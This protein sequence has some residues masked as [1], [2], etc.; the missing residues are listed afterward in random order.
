[1]L[2]LLVPTVALA[3]N[4]D[5]FKGDGKGNS[6]DKKTD[7]TFRLTGNEKHVKEF[8]AR[9]FTFNCN[10]RKDFK[11]NWIKFDKNFKVK[12]KNHNFSGKQSESSSGVVLKGKVSGRLDGKNDKLDEAH[13]RVQFDVKYPGTTTTAA[14]HCKSGKINWDADN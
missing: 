7:I 8:R 1:M 11:S 4:G 13:G 10:G 6:K 2:A 5:R 9:K 3:G 12:K 14:A